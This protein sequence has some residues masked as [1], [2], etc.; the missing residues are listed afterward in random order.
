[1]MAHQV[2]ST[3]DYTAYIWNDGK[4][5]TVYSSL[6]RRFINRSLL[7]YFYYAENSVSVGSDLTRKG[8]YHFLTFKTFARV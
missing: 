7:C 6:W 1:M 2:E 8:H 4:T 5:L 3:D